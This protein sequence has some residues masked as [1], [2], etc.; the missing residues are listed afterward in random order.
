[1]M[2]K[3]INVTLKA[4]FV[5]EMFKYFGHAGKRLD[6]KAKTNFNIYDVTNQTTNNYKSDNTDNHTTKS[7]HSI[8]YNMTNIF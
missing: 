3:E 2:G 5:L 8:E 4:L 6:N 1:M 7:D